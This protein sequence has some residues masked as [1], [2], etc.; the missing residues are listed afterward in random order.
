[1]VITPPVAKRHAY[2]I[3]AHNE[4]ELLQTLISL[5]DDSRNDIYVMIDKKVDLNQFNMIRSRRSKLMFCENRINVYWGHVS[6]IENEINLLEC[7]INNGE[8]SYLHIISGTD[9]PLK[10]QDY[11]HSFFQKYA[12]YEFIGFKTNEKA[13]QIIHQKIDTY[14]LFD[15]MMR[16]DSHLKNR[17]INRCRKI[18]NLL[19]NKVGVKRKY[20]FKKI[21]Y[22]DNWASITADFAKLLISQ[23][24][25]ILHD[26]RRT[27]AP[28][29]IYKQSRP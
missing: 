6:Q 17:I 14:Q 3:M 10:N 26:F 1:M 27:Y 19:Q 15:K 28:D 16:Y 29:E 21:G 11:I 9:L 24:K 18:G 22:G 5:I 8:Y 13:K 20:S 12:G 2:C 4:P 25:R 23:K 7:A